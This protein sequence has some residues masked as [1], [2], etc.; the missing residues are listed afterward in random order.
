MFIYTLSDIVGVV[1]L[2]GTIILC[3]ISAMVSK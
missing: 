3:V 1:F 2:V